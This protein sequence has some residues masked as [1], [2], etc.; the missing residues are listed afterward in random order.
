MQSGKKLPLFWTNTNLIGQ[1]ILAQRRPATVF[2]YISIQSSHAK[3]NLQHK[4]N[5]L[6]GILL[7]VWISELYALNKWFHCTIIAQM[8]LATVIHSQ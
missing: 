5:S 3:T 8:V 2:S 6:D 7:D 1:M 4:S